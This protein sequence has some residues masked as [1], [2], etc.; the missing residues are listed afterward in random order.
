M[1]I[2]MSETP[3]FRR[4]Y[5]ARMWNALDNTQHWDAPFKDWPAES[6]DMSLTIMRLFE[7]LEQTHNP[8]GPIPFPAPESELGP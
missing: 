1:V 6:R 3:L 8:F 2:H 4:F 5:A 7:S